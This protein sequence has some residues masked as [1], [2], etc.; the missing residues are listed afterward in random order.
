MVDAH[1]E[2]LSS[3]FQDGE[4]VRNVPYSAG[5]DGDDSLDREELS[6]R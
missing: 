5:A 2:S 3:P 4:E 6:G 1:Q